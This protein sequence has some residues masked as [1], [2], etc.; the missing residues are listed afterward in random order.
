M[1]DDDEL[2]AI[3]GELLA[4][5]IDKFTAKRNARVRELKTSGAAA[6]AAEVQ[7]LR[8]P[9]VPLWAANQLAAQ[10][11]VLAVV[12]EASLAAADA[13]SR[14]AASDLREASG[15][16]RRALDVAAHAAAEILESSGHS[17]T[18]DTRLKVRELVRLAALGDADWERLTRGALVDE[19]EPD[20]GFG[21]LPHPAERATRDAAPPKDSHRT[22]E[23]RVREDAER[24]VGEAR[25]A[26]ADD[27]RAA[28]QAELTAKHLREQ[29]AELRERAE[30][31]ERRAA[32]A[33]EA[34]ERARER[35]T[36]SQAALEALGPS[37][38]EQHP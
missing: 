30:S 33:Q 10:R 25:R 18:D 32:E 2:T 23:R 37:L 27:G 13:Q 36:A 22:D 29:A 3:T 9:T 38:D 35:A 4:T 11:D 7:K 14:G 8:R 17:S 24:R 31:A 6:L 28:E 19:P 21:P 12:R 34:A 20:I 16:L 5:P 26:A 15:R 1:A